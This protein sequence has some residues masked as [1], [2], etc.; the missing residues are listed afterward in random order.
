MKCACT[1]LS[2]VIFTEQVSLLQLYTISGHQPL[3]SIHELTAL[4]PS[5]FYNISFH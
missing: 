4:L 1:E 2:F 3:K 5:V